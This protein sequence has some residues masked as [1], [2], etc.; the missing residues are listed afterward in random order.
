VNIFRKAKR[1]VDLREIMVVD[2]AK[3]YGDYIA[4]ICPFHDDN[5]PSLLIYADGWYCTASTCP[6]PKGS[7]LDWIAYQR[8]IPNPSGSEM[9][10]IAREL[11]EG[12]LE[13]EKVRINRPQKKKV[14]LPPLDLDAVLKYVALLD[15]DGIAYYLSRGFEEWFIRW[16]MWGWC[17][18]IAVLPVWAGLPGQ[19]ELLNFRFRSLDGDLRYSGAKGYNDGT[20][21]NRWVIDWAINNDAPRLYVFYGEFD[22]ALALQNGIPSVSPT[23]G[24]KSFRPEWVSGYEGVVVI[25]PD[26]DEEGDAYQDAGQIGIMGEVLE[27][28]YPANSPDTKDFT[29]MYLREKEDVLCHFKKST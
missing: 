24:S 22:A 13:P 10:E 27:L 11:L 14:D 18:G 5:T 8:G 23:S 1:M 21:Y 26:R 28:D 17:D 29:D 20:V 12:T 9:L 2:G 15:T 6:R 25:V 7:V 19:S 16:N 3:S 4:G